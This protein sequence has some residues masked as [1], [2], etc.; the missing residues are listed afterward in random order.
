MFYKGGEKITMVQWENEDIKQKNPKEKKIEADFSDEAQQIAAEIRRSLQYIKEVPLE[1]KEE[2]K[3]A[4][5]GN[6]AEN[7]KEKEEVIETTKENFSHPMTEKNY[8]NIFRSKKQMKPWVYLT[9]AALVWLLLVGG[10][11]TFLFYRFN[12]KQDALYQAVELEIRHI[13]ENNDLAI[14]ELSENVQNITDA[15]EQISASMT[16]TGAAIDSSS[17]ANREALTEKI[18]ELDKQLASL[19]ESLRVL[20]EDKNAR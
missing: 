9:V 17:A 4:E 2:T 1:I 6:T 18:A 14:A 19:Q 11:F 12:A 10:S 13:Q 15:V 20:Q 3:E 5:Q 8:H 7:K 16:N